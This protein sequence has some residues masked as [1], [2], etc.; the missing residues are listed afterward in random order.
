MQETPSFA[1]AHKSLVRVLNDRL[2]STILDNTYDKR[3]TMSD[4]ID[5]LEYNERVTDVHYIIKETSEIFGFNIENI[6]KSKMLDSHITLKDIRMLLTTAFEKANIIDHTNNLLDKIFRIHEEKKRLSME[7]G[8]ESWMAH[9]I[10]DNEIGHIIVVT[11]MGRIVYDKIS[12]LYKLMGYTNSRQEETVA[13]YI[14]E[15][16]DTYNSHCGKNCYSS[17]ETQEESGYIGSW[18][19]NKFFKQ[20]KHAKQ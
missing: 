12:I 15:R 18:I 20:T 19:Y 7:N 17:V 4:S 14:L 5:S 3:I 8:K 2:E 16:G 13:I 6:S 10:E 11:A 9:C 1:L